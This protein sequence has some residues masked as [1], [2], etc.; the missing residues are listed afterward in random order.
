MSGQ[1]Q[2]ARTLIAAFAALAVS[3]V[4]V[5]AAVGPAHGIAAPVG[6]AINA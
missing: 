2:I 5:A 6:T 3:T 4:T 1:S